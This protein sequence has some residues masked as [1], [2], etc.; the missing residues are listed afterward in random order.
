MLNV[1]TINE[2][3]GPPFSDLVSSIN[4]SNLALNSFNYYTKLTWV[5]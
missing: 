4:R 5:Y 1:K 3:Y 2:S